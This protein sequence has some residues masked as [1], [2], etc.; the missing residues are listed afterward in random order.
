[1]NQYSEQL[2]DIFKETLGEY[3]YEY[4][5]ALYLRA[6]AVF[7]SAS[8]T[9]SQHQEIIEALKLLKIAKLIYINKPLTQTAKDL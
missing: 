8:K 1:M 2:C 5:D 4:A 6:K 9:N 7:A 3:S